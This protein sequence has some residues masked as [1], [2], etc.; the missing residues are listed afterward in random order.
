MLKY[1]ALQILAGSEH[2]GKQDSSEK[3]QQLTFKI[4]PRVAVQSS[5]RG[6]LW[7][8]TYA[9]LYQHHRDPK[10]TD[11]MQDHL[12]AAIKGWPRA[13]IA[14]RPR[15]YPPHS[16]SQDIFAAAR[17]YKTAQTQDISQFTS[18]AH[19]VDNCSFIREGKAS[20]TS[21]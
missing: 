2:R 16:C 5:N 12:F 8:L 11:R 21:N 7:D 10:I 13:G 17:G 19:R 6:Q 3:D 18:F 15:Y 4:S 9:A 20:Q 14:T 1:P